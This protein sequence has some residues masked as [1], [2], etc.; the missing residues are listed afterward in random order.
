MRLP[1]SQL[2]AEHGEARQTLRIV[3]R[4]FRGRNV[5]RRHDAKTAAQ[6]KLRGALFRRAG[7]HARER[8][9]ACVLED[10]PEQLGADALALESG[11]G[12]ERDDLSG[13]V[14]AI[15]VAKQRAH[16]GQVGAGSDPRPVAG[17]QDL[18]DLFAT[19]DLQKAVALPAL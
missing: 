6:E 13:R 12:V 5:G 8:A 19:A 2:Q 15:A 16:T 18:A 3:T 11:D 9:S 1:P 10:A 7:E 14:V 17:E 4:P